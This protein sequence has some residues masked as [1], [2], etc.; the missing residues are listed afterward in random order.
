MRSRPS[1]LTS[2]PAVFTPMQIVS[3]AMGNAPPPSMVVKALAVAGMGSKD[4]RLVWCG[5][6]GWD[7]VG[8]WLVGGGG[9]GVGVWPHDPTCSHLFTHILPMPCPL[10]FYP[11]AS[12]KGWSLSS[13]MGPVTRTT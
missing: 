12:R 6:W 2:P 11:R 10:H 9:A 1:H 13:G 3:S 5:V 7:S 4:L 8:H